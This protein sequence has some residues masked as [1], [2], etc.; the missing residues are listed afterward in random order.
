MVLLVTSSSRAMEC[1]SALEQSTRQKVRLAHSVA[2]AIAMLQSSEYAGLVIDESLVEVDDSA[3]EMLLHN[4]G[5][6]MPIYVNLGLHCMER[7]VRQVHAGL[8]RKH[9]EH[10]SARRAAET[11]LRGQLRG[12]VTGILLASE[13][14]L[15]EAA[16]SPQLAEK[17][18]SVHELAEKMRHRLEPVAM[19]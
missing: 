16:L 1:V 6:A 15:R 18:H 17:I 19:A 5:I 2:R 13:L 14:A 9:A 10:L 3:L 8:M 4:A 12:E 7:I 11:L